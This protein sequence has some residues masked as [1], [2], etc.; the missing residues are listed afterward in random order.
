M[1][2]F[3]MMARFSH[4]VNQRIYDCVGQLPGEKYRADCG[5]FFKSVHATLNHLLVVDRLWT[6]R[7][8]G[9]DRSIL[10]LDQTLHD[11]F[12]DL[13]AARMAEDQDMIGLMD[14]L[15][16]EQL[17]RQVTYWTAKRDRQMQAKVWDMLAGMFNH[18]T[19]H[20]GQITAVLMREGVSV[21]DIDLIYYLGETGQ[22][23]F[24]N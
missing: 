22:A 6:G 12:D 10:S 17:Q 7:V 20:R 3:P 5:L 13:R 1:R 2:H 11:E 9:V 19:H 8:T 4:W 21:P 18:Q 14:A 15:S 16:D 23:K 24:L